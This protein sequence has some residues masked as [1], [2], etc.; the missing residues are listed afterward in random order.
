MASRFPSSEDRVDEVGGITIG[1]RRP[2]GW[3]LLVIV[4]VVSFGLYYLI[5]YTVTE[6]GTFQAPAAGLIRAAL[7]L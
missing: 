4:G 3:L 5:T 1:Q 6:T 2:P 7:R